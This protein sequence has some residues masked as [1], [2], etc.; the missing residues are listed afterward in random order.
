MLENDSMKHWQRESWCCYTNIRQNR[1]QGKSTTRDKRAILK[2]LKS[3]F[4]RK[5]LQSQ[6]S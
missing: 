4:N 1:P 5:I 6:V 2:Y 3:Q